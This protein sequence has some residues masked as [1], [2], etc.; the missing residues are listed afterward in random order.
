[1]EGDTGTK[2]LLSLCFVCCL[3]SVFL[4]VCVNERQRGNL[5][6][7]TLVSC[8][9]SCFTISAYL[10]RRAVNPLRIGSVLIRRHFVFTP[11][12]AL[13]LYVTTLCIP[14]FQLRKKSTEFETLN[15]LLCW[16]MNS[17]I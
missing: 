14:T 12:C 2:S 8:W 11:H 15:L 4:S 7:K 17:G 6:N 9:Q 1:M 13:E 3:V 16:H 10:S 5:S